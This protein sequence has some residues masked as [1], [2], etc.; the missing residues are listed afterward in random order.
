M[1]LQVIAAA[2]LSKLV[3]RINIVGI[4][5]NHYTSRWIIDADF[6]DWEIF[7]VFLSNF[8]NFLFSGVSGTP[9]MF[10]LFCEILMLGNLMVERNSSSVM[11]DFHCILTT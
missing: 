9:G 10:P 4:L 6:N 11:K 1:Q 3:S 7:L 2:G 5:L 8:A